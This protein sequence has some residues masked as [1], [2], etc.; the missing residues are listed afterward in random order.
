LIYIDAMNWASN[1]S[2][3]L[4]TLG[5]NYIW[6]DQANI[7]ISYE[8]IKLRISDQY[9]QNWISALHDCEKL[10]IYKSYK[11]DFKL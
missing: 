10:F 3:L 1:V 9:Y 6:L 11:F 5:L 7:N 4:F 8:Y 2:D